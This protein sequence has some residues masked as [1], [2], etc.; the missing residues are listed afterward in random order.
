MS[1]PS[2]CANIEKKHGEKALLLTRKL[3]LL[4][5]QLEIQRNDT[6]VCIPLVRSPNDAEL[7]KLKTQIPDFQLAN[8]L[9]LRKPDSQKTLAEV[10]TG[11]LPSQLIESLPRALDI[12]GDIAIIEMPSELKAHEKLIG[13]AIL[14]THKNVHTVLA[15]AG[16]ITGEY[17]LREYRVIAGENRTDT[18]HREYGC[19][20]MVDIAKAYFSPRLSNEHKRVAALV[21]GNETVVDLFAGVGPFSVLIAKDKP[22]VKTFAIDIN[23]EAVKLLKNNIRLNRVEDR[24]IPLYG[25]ARHVV[26]EKLSGVADRVIMNLPEKANEF[27][28][29]ACKAL[30]PSGGVI[31]YYGFA[32]L[33]DS[34]ESKKMIIAQEV[35][36]NNR[37]L[38]TFLCEKT[39]R[40]T[41]PYEWQFVLDAKIR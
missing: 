10:L 33:P 21:E 2:L 41:A 13:A 28:D 22:G 37:E 1:E 36:K 3:G 38:N 5:K 23:S 26:E 9:L 31:H 40:E 14:R 20:F 27:V 19:K 7:L 25:D 34:I 18:V 4:N 15:K 12:I 29:V 35:K 32:R 30:K 6:H 17:R 39:V 11:Q 24:V 8:S 16:S